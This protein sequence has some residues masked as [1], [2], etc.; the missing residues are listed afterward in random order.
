MG[1]CPSLRS[2]SHTKWHA[3]ARARARAGS[4]TYGK[5][6][7]QSVYELSDNSGM[8]L[9]VRTTGAAAPGSCAVLLVAACAPAPGP[10]HAGLATQTAPAV[11]HGGTW[12]L[13]LEPVAPRRVHCPRTQLPLLPLARAQRRSRAWPQVGKYLTPNHTDIDRA[14]IKPD[15]KTAPSL[16]DAQQALSA[17]KQAPR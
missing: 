17:C 11:P 14:G 8:V 7:I 9:T 13:P 3:H 5:G 15:F 1:R 16:K 2:T 6:L 4:R 10:G 12:V